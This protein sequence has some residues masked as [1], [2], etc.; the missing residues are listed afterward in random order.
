VLCTS[1]V[2]KSMWFA[3]GRMLQRRDHH[4]FTLPIPV[5]IYGAGPCQRSR[6]LAEDLSMKGMKIRLGRGQAFASPL[7]G[8]LHLPGRSVSFAAEIAGS[9]LEPTGDQTVRLAADLADSSAGDAVRALLFGNPLQWDVNNWTD[10][11]AGK[12]ARTDQQWTF[13]RLKTGDRDLPCIARRQT[14]GNS[15]RVV[16]YAPFREHR[17]QALTLGDSVPIRGLRVK[18]YR[19]YAIGRGGVFVG[20]LTTG[21]D[22]PLAGYR[23]PTLH[24][25][26]GESL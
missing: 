8:K 13:C 19:S 3:T 5:T 4:R 7:R 24:P 22:N 2:I 14:D 26:V 23:F 10:L 17:I 12:R 20:E 1:L 25:L 16:A 6:G 21:G 15:W 18:S 9:R 11:G